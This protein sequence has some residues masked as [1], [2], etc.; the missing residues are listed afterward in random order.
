[1]RA[2]AGV[3]GRSGLS[4]SLVP[5]LA[6]LLLLG[7][8]LL[9]V[10]RFGPS[11]A[12]PPAPV[13]GVTHQG[14]A[15]SA[16]S[17]PV[18]TLAMPVGDV[19]GWREVFFDDFRGHELDYAKWRTYWGQP[20]GDSSGWF[21]PGHV[22]VSH[23]MMVISAYRDPHRADRWA[24]GGVSSGPG[25]IQTYGKYLVRFRMDSGMGVSAA[26]LLFPAN[27][28]WPPEIDFSENNGSDSNI[29]LATLHYGAMDSH[30]FSKLPVDMNQWHTLGVE[31]LPGSLT[32]TIDGRDW[33]HVAGSEVPSIPMVMDIQT[34]T[35]PCSGSWGRCPDASTPPDVRLDVHWVVAYAP[36]AP[37]GPWPYPHRHA[38]P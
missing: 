19:P 3:R 9:A 30:I 18:D 10:S 33:F 23:G 34:Q 38:G 1:M 7:A 36:A 6:G 32:F 27:N 15:P 24:T 12:T 16:V 17:T 22:T 13:R 26:L 8:V 4:A 25:L 31:W 29:T 21:E 11:A 37:L 5:A 2:I 28:S 20:G 14:T 35:W